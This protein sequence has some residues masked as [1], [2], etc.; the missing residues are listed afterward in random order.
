MYRLLLTLQTKLSENLDDSDKEI[1]PSAAAHPQG[2]RA[3]RPA[4]TPFTVA[5][6][7]FVFVVT[8]VMALR[9]GGL[10]G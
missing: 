5:S 10:G 9:A 6:V 7:E 3:P 4:S 1:G 8:V 2:R